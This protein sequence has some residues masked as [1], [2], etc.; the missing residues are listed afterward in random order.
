MN[1]EYWLSLLRPRVTIVY[2]FSSISSWSPRE[3]T[4]ASVDPFT[5]ESSALTGAIYWDVL[6]EWACDVG[7]EISDDY[8]GGELSRLSLIVAE[9]G[10][11][12]LLIVVVREF[13]WAEL[14]KLLRVDRSGFTFVYREFFLEGLSFLPE[15]WFELFDCCV[16]IPVPPSAS[17]DRLDSIM[18][19]V[20][21]EAIWEF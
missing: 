2:G 1:S 15:F 18:F 10:W 5:A 3:P 4:P 19:R 16:C 13:F 12:K 20:V 8:L 6:R 7:L 17:E 11:M 14:F 21:C 9:E